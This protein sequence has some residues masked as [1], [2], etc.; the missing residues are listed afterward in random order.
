LYRDEPLQL[1]CDN[2]ATI[3]IVNNPF[4]HDRTKHVGID[5]HFIKERLDEGALRVSFVK[6]IDQ[7]ADVLTKGVSVV[8]IMRIFDKMGLIDIFSPS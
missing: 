7:Q 5:R 8:S 4:H 1:Y 6:S 3:N 2:Q